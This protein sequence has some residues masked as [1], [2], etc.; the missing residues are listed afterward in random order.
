[1]EENPLI[2]GLKESGARMTA[3]RIAICR[4]LAQARSHPAVGDIYDALS[5]EF[6]TMSLATVYNTVSRLAELGL[7]QAIPAGD[8][9]R[10]RYDPILKPHLNLVCERCHRIIDLD[11]VDLTAVYRHAA[12]QGFAVT[13]TS[14]VVRGLCGNC[15]EQGDL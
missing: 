15:R 14:I 9:S 5:G 1:M 6:P 2:S 8:G 11:N 3:Q 4:M 10:T 7:V 13:Q 12:E